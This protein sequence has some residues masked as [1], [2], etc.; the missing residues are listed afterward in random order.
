MQVHIA[1]VNG[2]LWSGEA[3]S[4]TVP[5]SEGEMTILTGHIPLA[6]ALKAGRITVRSQAG[7][8]F[9]D[10]ESGVLEVSPKGAT[11]LL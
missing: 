9:F 6:S 5:G 4:L 3:K 10:I 8:E 2:V 7:E 1:K 11:V